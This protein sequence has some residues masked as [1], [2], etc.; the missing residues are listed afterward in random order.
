MGTYANYKMTITG[1][2]ATA[3]KVYDEMKAD[4][5]FNDIYDEENSTDGKTTTYVISGNTKTSAFEEVEDFTK[6]RSSVTIQLQSYT[7]DGEYGSWTYEYNRGERILV[8]EH[9]LF[10]N[11]ITFDTPEELRL[12]NTD[13]LTTYLKREFDNVELDNSEITFHSDE[14]IGPWFFE[15][16]S[17]PIVNFDFTCWY[18]C[19]EG[20]E[21][22][23]GEA[24]ELG[25]GM[26]NTNGKLDV[27][28]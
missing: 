15:D 28:Y 3:K 4:V 1:N 12:Y 7:D 18:E 22:A 11:T 10:K 9:I 2:T 17:A 13:I 20:N 6:N 24:G 14:P 5:W 23:V 19:I 16:I 8:E 25:H 26:F 21:V 27:I